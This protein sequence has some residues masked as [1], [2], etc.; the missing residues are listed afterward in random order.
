MTHNRVLFDTSCLIAGMVYPRVLL[1]LLPPE[2]LDAN[3]RL[4][5][6]TFGQLMQ[7]YS[8]AVGIKRWA[9]RRAKRATILSYKKRFGI[10][11]MFRNFKS[12]G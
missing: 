7:Q 9:K 4:L 3:A 1:G 12:G 5:T 10:E 11:E 6:P 8:Q 2:T